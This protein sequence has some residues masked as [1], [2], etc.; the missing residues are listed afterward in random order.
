MRGDPLSLAACFAGRT[1]NRLRSPSVFPFLRVIP[2][3]S[4]PSVN[5]RAALQCGP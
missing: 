2:V 1:S 5:S 3:S 4:V